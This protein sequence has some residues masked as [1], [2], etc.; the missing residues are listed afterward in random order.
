MCVVVW[1][2]ERKCGCGLL[3]V[4]PSVGPP[5]RGQEVE[6]LHTHAQATT[7]PAAARSH[8]TTRFPPRP[9]SFQTWGGTSRGGSPLCQAQC[10]A[11][12]FLPTLMD[13]P[14]RCT[15]HVPPRLHLSLL[16]GVSTRTG[17]AVAE[18]PGRG[19]AAQAPSVADELVGQRRPRRSRQDDAHI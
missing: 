13:T 9:C 18:D 6:L 15:G 14:A 2:R 7:A 3:Y 17:P 12:G 19:D 8:R 11:G 4:L 1:Q 10:P 16:R 5:A